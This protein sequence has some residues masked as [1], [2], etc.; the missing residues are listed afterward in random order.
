[1]AGELAG[2]LK[3][4]WSDFAVQTGRLGR[5]RARRWLSFRFPFGA[6]GDSRPVRRQGVRHSH[7]SNRVLLIGAT[8]LA[9]RMPRFG[10]GSHRL[11]VVLPAREW[12]IV[13]SIRTCRSAATKSIGLRSY[14]E[15]SRLGSGS[16]VNPEIVRWPPDPEASTRL[17]AVTIG[18]D[19]P[20]RS[21]QV[22]HGNRLSTKTRPSSTS[23]PSITRCGRQAQEGR[24]VRLS[25]WRL[26]DGRRFLLIGF[27][28]TGL[29][30]GLGRTS[31][32]GNQSESEEAKELGSFST[33]CSVS[34]TRSHTRCRRISGKMVGL[35][36]YGWHSDPPSFDLEPNVYVERTEV[37]VSKHTVEELLDL[38]SK[39][40]R[41]L[42]IYEYFSV[43]TWD[44][45]R[46]PG[47]RAADTGYLQESIRRYAAHH[48][49]SITSEISNSWGPHGRGYY[50]VS[51]LMWNPQA[52]VTTL[53]GDF[54]EKAFGPAAPAM[55]RY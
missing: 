45:D 10:S 28:P 26:K 34:Q 40:T 53:L 41:N 55:R 38:W 42:G 46:L 14:R 36:A 23:I 43:W 54:Y 22:T 44:F 4:I 5:R 35:L 9:H 37:H 6:P 13:P 33:R 32:G 30:H 12:E 1:V 3:Q 7:R 25:N 8:D 19:H 2:Y 49:K 24:Q 48:A 51:R 11:P 31:D 15:E 16:C 17:G 18:W 47:G 39:K 50:V 52:D 21:E 20:C 27:D 29:G